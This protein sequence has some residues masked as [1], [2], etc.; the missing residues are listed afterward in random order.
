MEKEKNITNDNEIDSIIN[1][2]LKLTKEEIINNITSE[3]KEYKLITTKTN[4]IIGES[5]NDDI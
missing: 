4:Y 5:I 1:E 3:P 2:L